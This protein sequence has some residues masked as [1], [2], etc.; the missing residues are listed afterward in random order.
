M[1]LYTGL[2]FLGC[3][4]IRMAGTTLS[5]YNRFVVIAIVAI[6][7]HDWLGSIWNIDLYLMRAV[8]KDWPDLIL[9]R[10]DG[11]DFLFRSHYCLTS[12]DN[13]CQLL[14]WSSARSFRWV[15]SS[16]SLEIPFQ[17]NLTAD[18]NMGCR[19]SPN[20]IEPICGKNGVTY[21]SPCH[22]GCQVAGGPRHVRHRMKKLSTIYNSWLFDQ[23]IQNYNN[24]ACISDSISH[25]PI[26]N[27]VTAVP[28]ATSGPCPQMCQAI[29]PFLFI[30]F[31]VTLVVSITQ[32]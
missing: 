8:L 23:Q 31:I 32:V 6:F 5:Y 30:L 13:W 28:M 25:E 3:D 12:A 1:G 24:C 22:A 2:Y 9:F 18:C 16:T 20:D 21:F 4:N 29:I 26:S 19:C 14:L 10:S 15:C 7:S 11:W 27:G 17:V